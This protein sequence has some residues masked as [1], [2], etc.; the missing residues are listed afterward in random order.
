MENGARYG[1]QE[2]CTG[3]SRLDRL[4]CRR[5]VVP[6]PGLPYPLTVMFKDPTR[7]CPPQAF[8]MDQTTTRSS[9]SFESP[10]TVRTRSGIWNVRVAEVNDLSTGTLIRRWLHL[11]PS[12]DPPDVRLTELMECPL[13]PLATLTRSDVSFAVRRPSTRTVVAGDDRVH[14]HS[15]R[16]PTSWRGAERLV[17]LTFRS[18][19]GL[20]GRLEM[21]HGLADATDAELLEAA[22]LG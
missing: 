3:V 17:T 6:S 2:Q 12:A 16:L 9:T 5:G 1:G 22:G 21:A 20:H 7:L 14:F 4:S 11:A 10:S 8:C 15:T 19:L 13:P 18:D